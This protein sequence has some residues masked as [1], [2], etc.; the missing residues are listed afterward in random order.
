MI[1]K[2]AKGSTPSHLTMP[3]AGRR[4]NPLVATSKAPSKEQTSCSEPYFLA[5]FLDEPLSPFCHDLPIL[6]LLGV[7]YC[8]LTGVHLFPGWLPVTPT[9]LSTCPCFLTVVDFAVYVNMA[10]NYPL[11]P[12]IEYGADHI[13]MTSGYSFS[14]KNG[15]CHRLAMLS[16]IVICIY[17]AE[18]GTGG[19]SHVKSGTKLV[20]E[21][22]N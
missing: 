12:C 8:P 7:I 1:A 21:Q 3:R 13:R 20:Q 17:E 16:W 10:R 22:A 2:A 6:F 9:G 18:W 5:A 11:L 14:S 19:R 4:G 15:W